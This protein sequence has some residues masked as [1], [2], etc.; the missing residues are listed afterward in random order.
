MD[1]YD[2]SIPF[3]AALSEALQESGLYFEI[4][5]YVDYAPSLK[6]GEAEIILRR[7]F[8][9][10]KGIYIV[11]QSQDSLFNTETDNSDI[12]KLT[13]YQ[14]FIDN[15]PISAQPIK[16]DNS[17][18]NAE[19]LFETLK[20][21]RLHGDL[22]YNSAAQ[23]GST[24][25][26]TSRLLRKYGLIGVDLEKSDLISGR[27]CQEIRIYMEN[28]YSNATAHVFFHYDKKILALPGFQFSQMA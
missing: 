17:T 22:Q 11:V 6:S 21:L 9:S 28:D 16:V 25:F 24:K 1:M 3:R 7:D 26:G 10:L 4:D 18:S 20:S 12:S 19:Q 5:T 13:R 23:S 27:T 15:R 2:F 14:I 8:S